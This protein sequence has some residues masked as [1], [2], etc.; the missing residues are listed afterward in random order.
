MNEFL[1]GTTDI[2]LK[3]SLLS[4]GAYIIILC[5]KMSDAYNIFSWHLSK[6]QTR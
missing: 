2:P 5:I 4:N 1:I 3:L 6:T